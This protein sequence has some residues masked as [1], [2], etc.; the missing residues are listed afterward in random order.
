MKDLII[1]IKSMY[2]NK[3]MT[4]ISTSLI[5]MTMLVFSILTI[6]IVNVVNTTNNV[7]KGIK[8][9]AYLEQD[10]SQK[11]TDEIKS[12]IL[13]LDGV[14]EVTYSSRDDE[15]TRLISNL[16]AEDQSSALELFSGDDNP[17]YN[18][19]NIEV[20]DSSVDREILKSS[21]ENIDGVS[22][23]LNPSSEEIF[24]NFLNLIIK[25]AVALVIFLFVITLLLINNTINL[26]I[27][28]RKKEIEIMKLVGAKNSKVMAPFLF[29][30]IIMGLIGG[31]VAILIS[32]YVY[33]WLLEMSIF[34]VMPLQLI[35]PQII[36]HRYLIFVPIL[37]A[38]IG[39][40]SSFF[41]VSKHT[42]V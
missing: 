36:L 7:S 41:T 2:R 17:L 21:I 13:Q 28:H 34:A 18:I 39:M 26:T 30:G 23:V 9:Y 31:A 32:Y 29:E 5:I 27:R 6:S 12:Q 4:I 11:K 38:I 20:V 25:I 42:K 33:S 37:S 8:I 22:F 15:L 1:A 3:S 40:I 10:M 14:G 19:Y 35:T 16:S 24:L